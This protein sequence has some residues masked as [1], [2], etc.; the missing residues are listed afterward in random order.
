[1]NVHQG[2]P[3]KSGIA[4]G[5]PL[6]GFQPL[7]TPVV[8]KERSQQQEPTGNDS[9]VSV[10][11]NNLFFLTLPDVQRQPKMLFPGWTCILS[12][13][14]ELPYQM[15]NWKEDYVYTDFMDSM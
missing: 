10:F 4:H 15:S 5:T 13:S 2:K 11:G 14:C 7:H 8:L 6:P 9:T 12:S 3:V 1:M